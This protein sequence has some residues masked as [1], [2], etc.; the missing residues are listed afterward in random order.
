MPV[1]IS[2]VGTFV[3]PRESRLCNDE[4]YSH[5]LNGLRCNERMAV[6]NVTTLKILI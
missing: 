1:L 2:V 3:F 6:V 5:C 4:R